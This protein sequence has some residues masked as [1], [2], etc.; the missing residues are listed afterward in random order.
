MPSVIPR[1]ISLGVTVVTE[2]RTVN[3]AGPDE[4]VG[5]DRVEVEDLEAERVRWVGSFAFVP[6]ASAVGRVVVFL[7]V[8]DEVGAVWGERVMGSGVKE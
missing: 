4:V 3:V 1:V 2:G 5:V 8:G 7:R 6:G